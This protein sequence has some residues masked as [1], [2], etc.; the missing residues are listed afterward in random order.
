LAESHFRDASLRGVVKATVAP[1]E[2]PELGERVSIDGPDVKV[3]PEAV[4]SLTLAFHEL[5]T[6]GA[7]YGA[8]SAEQGR[9][10]V[11]WRIVRDDDPPRFVL[12]WQ[13]SGGPPIASPP[14]RTGFG[15]RL[16]Q[17]VLALEI[18]GDVE[19]DYSGT[20][21]KVTLSAPVENVLTTKA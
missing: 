16:L 20:G 11:S 12:T 10:A 3:I 18:G 14:S 8:L 7:K 9:I 1:Y 19:M 15:T 13:E 21:L 4:Q 17:Q 6:N 2:V 5:A